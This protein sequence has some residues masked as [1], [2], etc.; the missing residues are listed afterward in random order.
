VPSKITGTAVNMV[1]MTIQFKSKKA[2]FSFTTEE[3]LSRIENTSNILFT[4]I[5]E[6][7]LLII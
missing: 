7:L 6:Y 2:S 5:A 1:N 4:E 3:L